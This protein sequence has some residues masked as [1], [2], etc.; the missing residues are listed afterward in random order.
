MVPHTDD[1]RVLFVIPWHGRGIVGTTDTAMDNPLLEPRA[2]PNE[3]DF[4][5]KNASRYMK[6]D[7]TRR[8]ILSVFAGQRPLV[9]LGGKSKR[10]KSISRS[11]EVFVSHRGLVTI[12]GEVL[13]KGFPTK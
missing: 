1:Q 5:L 4:I 10:T 7:P 3:I 9:H 6:K 13:N 2:L 11:H 12:T 8:D